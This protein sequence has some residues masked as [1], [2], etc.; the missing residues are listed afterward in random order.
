[1]AHDSKLAS[2]YLGLNSF[3]W[4]DRHNFYPRENESTLLQ[5]QVLANRLSL[6]HAPSG[7]GK[8]SLINAGLL[9]P[10][11][12]DQLWLAAVA[13]PGNN[14]IA[15]I[16]HALTYRLFPH[17][18]AEILAIKSLVSAADLLRENGSTINISSDLALSD[19]RERFEEL[20]TPAARSNKSTSKR[21]AFQSFQFVSNAL[22]IRLPEEL[23]NI[24]IE[25]S[26]KSTAFQRFLDYGQGPKTL[27]RHLAGIA[28][29]GEQ[30]NADLP[31][32]PSLQE[33]LTN[34]DARAFAFGI[35]EL[36]LKD[37]E[38]F[39]DSQVLLDLWTKFS[40]KQ[41]DVGTGEDALSNLLLTIAESCFQDGIFATGPTNVLRPPPGILVVLDQFEEIFTRFSFKDRDHFFKQL[42]HAFGTNVDTEN[43]LASLQRINLLI[44]MRDEYVANL[45][46]L[47]RMHRNL[48]SS[49]LHLGFIR[50]S[51]LAYTIK[52]PAEKYGFTFDDQI[53]EQLIEE[54]ALDDGTIE[55]ALVQI[56]LAYLWQQYG[57][58]ITETINAA[59]GSAVLAHE[60]FEK[61]GSTEIIMGKYIRQIIEGFDRPASNDS[62]RDTFLRFELLDILDLLTRKGDYRTILSEDELLAPAGGTRKDE[63]IGRQQRRKMLEFAVKSGIVRRYRQKG[64]GGHRGDEAG[65]I[66]EVTHERLIPG[67]IAALNETLRKDDTLRHLQSAR[68][69]INHLQPHEVRN[70]GETIFNH[71]EIKAIQIFADYIDLTDLQAECLFRSAIF[72]TQLDEI[73]GLQ[74]AA[75]I[76][77]ARSTPFDI[78]GKL[79]TARENIEAGNWLDRLELRHL[80]ASGWPKG[81]SQQQQFILHSLLLQCKK[82]D[83][84]LLNDFAQGSSNWI[85]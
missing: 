42:E 66:V 53:I 19:I 35:S 37:L 57:G 78:T 33:A 7:A 1:M 43:R 79:E 27:V 14:P 65:N 70:V 82:E 40:A 69:R 60:Q 23:D 11:E 8:T 80:Q 22:K 62:T 29:L 39:F 47:Q 30:E 3:Q 68:A 32:P 48:S 76:F 73:D 4:Q 15:E 9:A 59:D 58:H 2:P 52:G 18:H 74:R 84:D 17:P 50:K 72:Q 61:L 36:S 51:E 56:V 16:A 5:N 41:F 38:T 6:L 71:E 49:T 63:T 77:D 45:D 25:L 12:F 44:S 21:H 81:D 75:K 54:L 26:L 55:P 64:R 34:R 67:I 85:S 28:R 24:D 13:R 10:L 31:W 46:R 20:A 83:L